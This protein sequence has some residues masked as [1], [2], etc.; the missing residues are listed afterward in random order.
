MKEGDRY[1]L[2]TTTITSQIKGIT[3]EN[4]KPSVE[5]R[6]GDWYDGDAVGRAAEEKLDAAAADSGTH[7]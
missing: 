6:E 2:G 1:R 3:P 7:G 5:L 4:L